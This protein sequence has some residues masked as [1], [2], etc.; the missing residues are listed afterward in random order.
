MS[1]LAQL[2]AAPGVDNPAP[3]SWEQVGAW[4]R[5]EYI[6]SAMDRARRDRAR[7]RHNLYG[8]AGDDA[9]AT[10]I[11]QVFKDPEVLQKRREWLDKAKFNNVSKRIVNE[12]A[13]VYSVPAARR[14]SDEAA[15][16]RYQDVQRDC[17]QHEVARR[18]NRWGN[19]HGNLA[20]GFRVRDDASTVIDVVTPE[21]FF[22]VG[23]PLDPSQQI[24]IGI[25]LGHKGPGVTKASPAWI[26]WSAAEWFY[27]SETGHVIESS[28]TPHSFG[29]IPWVLYAAEPAYG[30]LLDD[31]VGEDIRAAHKAVWFLHL[32]E[33]KEAK[34]ATK[35]PVI[36]GDVTTMAREASSDS[37]SAIEAPDGVTIDVVDFSMDISMFRDAAQRVYEIVAG[38]NGIAPGVLKH[39]G[40]QSAQA[41]ELMLA[42]LKELRREQEVYLRELEREFAVVQSMVL[43]RHNHPLAFDLEGWSIDFSESRTPLDPK[44]ALEV[45][46]QKRRLGLTDTVQE[47]MAQNPDL[48]V[49]DAFAELDRH[50]QVET[51]RNRMMRPLQQI[52]GSMAATA[53]D[54]SDADSDGRIVDGDADPRANTATPA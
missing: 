47:L 30:A 42:P 2:A 22:A 33:L 13:V 40:V 5:S 46:E 26:V 51:T 20:L 29:R 15:N 6:N 1:I 17:R 24:A 54:P 11:G 7:E 50:I 52:S 34:S 32:L 44:A 14:V 18:W 19:L 48:L 3:L 10:F 36:S 21:H 23:H 16:A 53:D 38:N 12:R 39:S 4:L 37:E 31:S 9:M 28:V 27:V 8:G 25:K 35:Q 43:T 45:F 41:R 49:S